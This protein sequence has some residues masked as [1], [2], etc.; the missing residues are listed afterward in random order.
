M[1]PLL[2]VA[3]YGSDVLSQRHHSEFS[4]PRVHVRFVLDRV[5]FQLP[6]RFALAQLRTVNL[7]LAFTNENPILQQG[8]RPPIKFP[9]LNG[10]PNKVNV[11]ELS[12]MIGML[13]NHSRLCR[14]NRASVRL[15]TITYA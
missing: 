11:L 12:L 4:S 2:V 15:T 7:W 6:G 1:L 5:E 14:Y 13:E 3:A 10:C 9:R 8:K